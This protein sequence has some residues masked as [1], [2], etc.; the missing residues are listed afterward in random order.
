MS[1]GMDTDKISSSARLD[2]IAR[3]LAGAL[4]RMRTKERVSRDNSLGCPAETRPLVINLQ[5]KG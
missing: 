2:E 1:N 4:V 5:R 3:L